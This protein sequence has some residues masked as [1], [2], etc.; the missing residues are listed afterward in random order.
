MLIHL[1]AGVAIVTATVSF[2]APTRAGE[3]AG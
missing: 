3:L 2:A 1:L